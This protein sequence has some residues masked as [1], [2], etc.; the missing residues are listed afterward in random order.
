MQLL[1]ELVDEIAHS[2]GIASKTSGK[3]DGL[4]S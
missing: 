2:K 3:A 1:A 4:C